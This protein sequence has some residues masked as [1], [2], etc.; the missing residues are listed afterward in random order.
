M[1]GTRFFTFYEVQFE[2]S[3]VNFEALIASVP[4]YNQTSVV[5]SGVR[6]GEEG[7]EKEKKKVW[8]SDQRL[9]TGVDAGEAGDTL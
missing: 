8:S 7:K 5:G 3:I 6:E 4:G 1:T 2:S 9:S